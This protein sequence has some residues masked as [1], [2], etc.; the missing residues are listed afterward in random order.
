MVDSLNISAISVKTKLAM[1]G[2]LAESE[3]P[4]ILKELWTNIVIIVNTLIIL[5][6]C[7]PTNNYF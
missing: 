7:T 1:A 6:Y 2:W 4:Q 3:H 5:V